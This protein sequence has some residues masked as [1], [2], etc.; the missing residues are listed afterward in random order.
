[1]D[2]GQPGRY[3]LTTLVIRKIRNC[4][5][6]GGAGTIG[7]HVS[8]LFWP[9]AFLLE[10]LVPARLDRWS[11]ALAAYRFDQDEGAWK[12]RT[13]NRRRWI[14]PI[15]VIIRSVVVIKPRRA[16]AYVGLLERCRAWV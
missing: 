9:F 4:E 13:P 15:F 14:P 6:G 12:W 1:M 11:T 8:Y 16:E 5:G 2:G 10:S 7:Y 3:Y